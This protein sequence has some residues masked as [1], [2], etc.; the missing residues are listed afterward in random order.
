[1]HSGESLLNVRSRLIGNTLQEFT[2][3]LLN[4]SNDKLFSGLFREVC[5]IS[6]SNPDDLVKSLDSMAKLKA[7]NSRRANPEE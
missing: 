3:D 5:L 4:K 7:P 1:V 6:R 2:G